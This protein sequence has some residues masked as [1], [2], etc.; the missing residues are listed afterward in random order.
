M[1]RLVIAALTLIPALAPA[2]DYKGLEAM[3]RAMERDLRTTYSAIRHLFYWGGTE[4]TKI[5]RDQDDSGRNA[6]LAL[7]PIARQGELSIDDGANWIQYYPDSRTLIIQESPLKRLEDRSPTV[8]YEVMKRNYDVRFEA[9]DSV[10]GR[11]A[12]RVVLKPSAAD[13]LYARR[14]WVDADTSVLLRVEWTDPA[15]RSQVVS[16]TLFIEYPSAL[17]DEIFRPKI[18]GKPRTIEVQAPKRQPSIDV[19]SDKVGFDVILPFQ[20]P[21]GFFFTGADSVSAN[22]RALAALRFT[23]GATNVTI[24]Q[25]RHSE[26]SPPWRIQKWRGDFVM[27]GLLLAVEG[28][29]PARGR[30]AVIAALKSSSS[31]EAGL[32]SRCQAVTGYG[33]DKVRYLRNLGWGYEDVTSCLLISRRDAE[34]LE[35][36]V[37]EIGSGKSP[38]EVAR[39]MGVK[40]SDVRS[41]IARLWDAN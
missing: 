39:K 24:Y 9:T 31:G 35:K 8:R 41:A 29:L 22:N 27:N 6:V 13:S 7:A 18:V 17:A 40:E 2:S 4:P 28:D 20:M 23:D 1:P 12:S 3:K 36:C 32:R 25:A 15:G 30:E 21:F 10:A 38:F 11:R 16:D 37:K 26:K 5:R 14:F 33:A 19:L 34:R